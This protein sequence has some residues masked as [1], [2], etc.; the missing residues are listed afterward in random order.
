MDTGIYRITNILTRES[1]IGS[2]Q[3]IQKRWRSHKNIA[4]NKNVKAYSYPLS[5]AIRE[6]GI[7]NFTLTILELCH[8][9]QL[10]SREI[11][12]FKKYKPEYCLT[13]PEAHFTQSEHT[14][15]AIRQT[16]KGRRPS[17]KAIENAIQANTG[18]NNHNATPVIGIKISDESL[19]SF[20]S[21]TEAALWIIGQSLSSSNK[22]RVAAMISRVV[23]GRRGSA[24]GYMWSKSTN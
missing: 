21:Q 10:L 12:Y 7:D 24:Y 22:K 16:L 6:F 2:S 8:K 19:V 13:S 11:Y 9:D 23:T 4:F 18:G 15:N 17:D 14:R 5:E 1:Y 20:A 3:D